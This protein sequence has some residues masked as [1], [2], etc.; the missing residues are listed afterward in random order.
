MR[1]ELIFRGKERR[2]STRVRG[3]ASAGSLTGLAFVLLVTGGPVAE[4]ADAAE[5]EGASWS[6]A[7]MASQYRT[8][9]PRK[10]PVLILGDAS[11]TRTELPK[12]IPT[13][14]QRT[15]KSGT[16][17]GPGKRSTLGHGPSPSLKPKSGPAA[18]ARSGSK[19][20]TNR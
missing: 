10:A 5:G 3:L 9:E 4:R 13:F 8:P 16:Y 18:S 12:T 11:T 17:T 6:A 7:H 15:W 2:S 1:D 14:S 20:G 19:R